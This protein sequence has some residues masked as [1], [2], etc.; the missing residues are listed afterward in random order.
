MQKEEPK[1]ACW[2]TQREMELLVIM[3][4]IDS[5]GGWDLRPGR[6]TI[7]F[8]YNNKPSHFNISQTYDGIIV[9]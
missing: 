2:L 9:L 5:F 8:D 7:D 1:T 6:L 3:K 4:K